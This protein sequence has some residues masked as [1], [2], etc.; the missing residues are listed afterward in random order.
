M[1]LPLTAGS[2]GSSPSSGE[3]SAQIRKLS[4]DSPSSIKNISHQGISCMCPT[5]LSDQ[6]RRAP[7]VHV[8]AGAIKL[9]VSLHYLVFLLFSAPMEL[10]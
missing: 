7:T 1:L 8:G 3:K 10:L 5:A 6:N 9:S 4:C 2:A